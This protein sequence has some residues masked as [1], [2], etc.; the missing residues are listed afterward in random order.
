MAT[1][2]STASRVRSCWEQV[3]RARS[4]RVT[5]QATH[6]RRGRRAGAGPGSARALPARLRGLPSNG[7]CHARLHL[8]EQRVRRCP[9]RR[10]RPV[11]PPDKLV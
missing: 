1:L 2:E 4:A 6:G 7:T 3:R 9:R 8:G 11:G 5:G 10:R